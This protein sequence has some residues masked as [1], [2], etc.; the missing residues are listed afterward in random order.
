M[1]KLLAALALI[2][3]LS[4]PAIAIAQ[5]ESP[6]EGKGVITGQVQNGTEGGKAAPHVK[7]L[8]HIFK[9]GQEQETRQAET[10]ESG[11]FRFEGLETGKGYSY[12]VEARYAG[13]SYPG[14]LT[15]FEEGEKTL[16]LSITVYETTASD[17]EIAIERA[18]IVID[19]KVGKLR[20]AEIHILANQGDRTYVG[21]EETE[22]GLPLTLRFHL[23]AGA[24]NLN[25]Q[26]ERP[27]RFQIL[28]DGFADTWP[29]LPGTS[30]NPLL[31]SY[32]IGY[33]TG[34]FT[35]P[36]QA[37]YPMANVS[38][39]VAAVGEEVESQQL[40]FKGE[41]EAGGKNYLH[42]YGQNLTQGETVTL[43]FSNLSLQA[44]SITETDRESAPRPEPKTGPKVALWAAIG[45]AALVLFGGALF[46]RRTDVPPDFEDQAPEREDEDGED[47]EAERE[48]L[49][50][51]MARLDDDFESGRIEEEDYRKER[52]ARKELLMAIMRRLNRGG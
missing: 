17:E 46:L 47:L 9:E 10:D 1:K 29:L 24:E 20:I 11:H 39:L 30:P 45:V 21:V 49:I 4:A 32:E 23:P 16:S 36:F 40:T 5:Q 44:D 34:D 22:K 41:T 25:F 52:K 28:E 6:G 27:G 31:F 7:L 48:R 26:D 14:P 42:F 38:F 19:F 15:T 35:L 33:E 51:T 18:H 2:L 43:A 13:L 8:L 37:D 50:Q 3:F 12:G